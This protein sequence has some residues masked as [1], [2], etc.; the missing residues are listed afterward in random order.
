MRDEKALKGSC[1][2]TIELRDATCISIRVRHP[3]VGS[4]FK[5]QD[6]ALSMQARVVIHIPTDAGPEA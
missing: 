6:N 1:V 3:E 5:P 2:D 4:L